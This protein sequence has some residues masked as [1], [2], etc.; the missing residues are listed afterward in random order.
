MRQVNDDN[1]QKRALIVHRSNFKW[2]YKFH[3]KFN[4]ISN[5][6]TLFIHSFNIN[7]EALP[8]YKAMQRKAYSR[9]GLWWQHIGAK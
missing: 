7:V 2:N 3:F 4:F 8:N 9:F 1:M 6:S 5:L